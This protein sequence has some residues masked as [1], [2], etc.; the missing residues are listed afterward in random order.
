MTEVRIYVEGGGDSA[1]TKQFLRE[2]FSA[3]L[4]ELVSNAR[5]K[6]IRWQ[7]V[8]CG[9][10][11]TTL[12]L[13]KNALRHHPD[14]F[15]AVLV[16]SESPV[17]T[18]PWRHLQQRNEWKDEHPHDDHCQFMTQA[19]EAWLIADTEALSKF[20]GQGFRANAIRG[21]PDV[22]QIAKADLETS[23]KQATR[24]TQKGEYHKIK[25]AWK[26]LQ[27]IEASKVRKASR[28]CERFFAT[29]RRK[30]DDC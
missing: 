1:D 2:G 17:Q 27:I 23:L 13:F 25:H 6:R 30:M 20:Y 18:T 8:I 10:R 7:I 11:D 16:D 29:V 3:F 21:N 15:N 28:Q 9:G 19:M 14:A 24:D 12:G 26:L 22:E 5:Q 4:K